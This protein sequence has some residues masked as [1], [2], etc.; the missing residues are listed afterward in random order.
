MWVIYNELTGYEIDRE[1]NY[2]TAKAMVKA[3]ND[4]DSWGYTYAK[5][6]EE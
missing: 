4:N 6:W 2:E 3:L 5:R 1:E